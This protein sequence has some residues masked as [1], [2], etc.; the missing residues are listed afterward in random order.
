MDN[1]N[2][3][4]IPLVN[5]LDTLLTEYNATLRTLLSQFDTEANKNTDTNASHRRQQTTHRLVSLDRDLQTIYTEIAQ[6][7]ARQ[8]EI[9][10][11]QLKSIASRSAKLH[12]IENILDAKD[13]LETVVFDVNK[14]LERAKLA[15]DKMPELEEIV[16]YAK[17]ISAYTKAPP[18]YDPKNSAVPAEP[19]YPVEVAMRM[20]VLNQYRARR[21]LKVE[22]ESMM[23][24]DEDE[25]G[26]VAEEFQF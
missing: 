8:E 4:D 12:F 3:E 16:E 1:L 20:G 17:K 14:K 25:F 21:A 5:L 7:Q 9:R 24:E 15:A 23:E 13:Q 18:N 11:T 2:V 22:R 6:H 19:P 10:Q 26:D